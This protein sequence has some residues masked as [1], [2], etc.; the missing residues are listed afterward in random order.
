MAL[1]RSFSDLSIRTKLII[2]VA[3]TLLLAQMASGL[4]IRD[5]VNHHIVQQAITTVVTF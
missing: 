1:P 3:G 2:I 4:F 5:L